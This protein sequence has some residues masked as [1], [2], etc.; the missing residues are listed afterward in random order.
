MPHGTRP[1]RVL[2]ILLSLATASCAA[3]MARAG[4]AEA[5]ETRTPGG[6]PVIEES[7]VLDRI[8][9]AV[10]VR[11]S[12]L[13]EGERQYVAYFNADRRMVVGMRNLG[14]PEFVKTVLPSLS[15]APPTRG[16]RSTIQGWDSHNYITMAL[17]A[18]G[19]L[20]LAGNMHANPLTYFRSRD[21]HDV[22]TLEPVESMVGRL[23]NRVTYPRF[24]NA[25]DGRLVF[26]YRHGGSGNG[27]EILNVYDE[28]TRTWRR[29]RDQPLLAGEGQRNAYPNGPRLGPDGWHHLLWVWRRTPA[30]ETCHDL[31]YARS[32]DLVNWENA[33][34]EAL[35]LPI[36]ISSPGTIVDPIPVNG[37]IINGCQRFGFDRRNRVLVTYHKH[38][39]RGH[40]QAYVARFDDGRWQ[41]RPV[42][43]WEGEHVFRGGGSGPSTFGTSL[44]LGTIEPYSDGKLALPYRHWIHGRGVLV[45]DEETLAPLGSA[46]APRRPPRFPPELTRVQSDFPGMQVRW[47][48]D[49]GRSPKAG[50]RYVLRWESLGTHRDRP[51]SGPLPENSELV[52]YRIGDVVE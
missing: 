10:R 35:E 18:E 38:D 43:D 26:L 51:R 34:G 19:H 37:G 23:E 41:T 46:A 2:H 25:P 40:T 48:E 4:D 36:T 27:D 31:S 21:P 50:S 47:T 6:A 17:D 9:S 30:A 3:C 8:W 12:L 14:D 11:F 22:T 16:T 7:I 39:E 29:L 42:S 1:S 5:T 33:A 52:L 13:T 15:D 24:M 20:H 49:E 28:A 45:V 44:W 32:R